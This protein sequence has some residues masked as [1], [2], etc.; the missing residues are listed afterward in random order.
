[1]DIFSKDP[2]HDLSSI[3][4]QAE[5]VVIVVPSPCQSH[6]NQLLHLSCLISSY[7]IP[8]LYATTATHLRQVKLRFN[9]T[10]HLQNSKIHFHEFPTPDFISP[11][12]TPNPSTKFPTHLQPLIDS[13]IHLRQ[14]MAALLHSIS[15]AA[16]KVIVVHDFMMAYVVQDVANVPNAESYGFNLI[17]AFSFFFQ[18][19][20]MKGKPFLEEPPP[21]GL[22]DLEGYCP[23]E[24]INFIALQV[25]FLKPTTGYI[26]NSCRSIE[27]TYIDLLAKDELN[28][29]I[30]AIG[31]MNLGA[32]Y[33]KSNSNSPKHKCLEWLDKQAPKSVLYVSFGTTTT[34]KDEEIKELAMG[35]EQSEQKFIWVFRDAD[36][37]DIFAG[38]VQT[39]KLPEGF[40]ERV[41]EVGMV[42]RDWA[43]QVDILGHPST[44]GFM[45]HCGWN[46]CLESITMG[47]PIATWPMH[48]DQPKNAFL[49]TDILKVGLP[50][51]TWEQREKIVS[52]STIAKDVKKLMASKEGEEMRKRAEE[53][54]ASTRK[55]VEDGGV[56]RV[57]LD[58]FI[59]H[60]TRLQPCL[61]GDN[62]IFYEMILFA[63]TVREGKDCPEALSQRGVEQ[64]RLV[65]FEEPPEEIRNKLID[66]I[67]GIDN[68]ATCFSEI[69]VV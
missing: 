23:P 26:Y 49:V 9:N 37:G 60:I 6:L 14:P 16:R 62:S 32:D 48:S 34:M 67:L 11:P 50:V 69:C 15:A 40:E 33:E 5:V 8:I 35:L 42:V 38:E 10:T 17:S 53:L 1:M 27:G 18:G 45:S 68:C 29:P 54:G 39:K 47:V 56:S 21:K 13:I 4:K 43:P 41:K 12:P 52:S 63:Q 22:P 20:E 19:W 25:D 7:N 46:S 30:W 24:V 59:A 51:N 28:K 31:P 65:A 66:D 61:Y 44:S 55:A 58:S 64:E 3:S 36:K 2:S 57:E